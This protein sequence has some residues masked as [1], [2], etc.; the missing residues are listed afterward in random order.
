MRVH[1]SRR[2]RKVGLFEGFNPKGNSLFTMQRVER[3]T[4]DF[5]ATM[6]RHISER[7][8]SGTATTPEYVEHFTV[9]GSCMFRGE[10]SE[11]SVTR[12]HQFT[13]GFRQQNRVTSPCGESCK[14]GPKGK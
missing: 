11:P 12:V 7:G 9:I 8:V 4:G 1:H 2:R 10:R 13:T 3:T 6:F 14:Y 5:K